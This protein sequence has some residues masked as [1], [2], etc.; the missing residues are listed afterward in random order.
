MGLKAV[1]LLRNDP[2]RQSLSAAV[3]QRKPTQSAGQPLRDGALATVSA[4][5]H[6]AASL[7]LDLRFEDLFETGLALTHERCE[8]LRETVGLVSKDKCGH[9][10]HKRDFAALVDALRLQ[11]L[12]E[13][14]VRTENVLL[15]PD[16]NEKL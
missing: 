11:K 14:P 16:L 4:V 3:E 13:L 7:S 6:R 1:E 10:E 15:D 12:R 5:Y 8:A 2:V 9:A